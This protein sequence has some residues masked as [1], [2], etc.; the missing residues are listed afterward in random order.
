MMA[1]CH[2]LEGSIVRF[3]SF[4]LTASRGIPLSLLACTAVGGSHPASDTADTGVA[5]PSCEN[6]P[7]ASTV[8]CDLQVPSGYETI[9]AA[10]DASVHG[11]FVCVSA[12]TYRETIDFDGKAIQV[13]GIHGVA[14]T[15]IDGEQEGSVVTF[16]TGEGADT[17]FAGFT[18]TNGFAE[19]GGGLHLDGT[20]P[21][22]SNLVVRNNEADWYGGG[23]YLH[24]SAANIR[25]VKITGN[26]VYDPGDTEEPMGGGLVLRDSPASLTNLVV[27]GNRVSGG[28]SS[29]AGGMMLYRS[30]A[31]LTSIA[32]VGNQCLGYGSAGIDFNS[33]SATVTNT[34]IAHNIGSSAID[35]RGDSEEQPIFQYCNLFHS[36]GNFIDGMDDPTGSDGNISEDPQ[37]LDRT[38]ADPA[39]WD[40]HL[41]TQSS[42]IDAGGPAFM[43]PDGSLY[44]MGVY[45]GPGAALWDLD[46]DGY[47]LW[48]Q[49]GAYD[50]TT[51]PAGCWDCDD[52]DSGVHAEKGC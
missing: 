5:V 35:V 51:Y 39:D 1:G 27:A 40:L 8:V 28:D 33:S 23:I 15:T 18:V 20:S 41:S 43:D 13:L 24:E 9:Q 37:F 16:A 25:N 14:R 32:V 46:A 11:E 45:G 4:L 48:W 47:P 50:S 10:I 42:S 26:V 34:I 36:G 17:V 30:S 21:T 22:I 52:E 19:R 2:R 3:D 29:F 31:V 12:G 7:W 38:P 49:P 6:E 44:D